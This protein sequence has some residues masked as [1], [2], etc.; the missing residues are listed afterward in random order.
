MQYLNHL[1]LLHKKKWRVKID[2]GENVHLLTFDGSA[3]NAVIVLVFVEGQIIFENMSD[4][5]RKN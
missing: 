4:L 1:R 2:V 3:K 5:I